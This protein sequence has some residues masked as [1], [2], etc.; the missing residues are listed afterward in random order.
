METIIPLNQDSLNSIFRTSIKYPETIAIRESSRI[1]FKESFNWGSRE[2]YARTLAAFAN[3]KGGYIIYGIVN[4]TLQLIG[5]KNDNFEKIDPGIISGYL[6]DAFSPEIKWHMLRYEFQD[7]YFGL[8]YVEESFD[9]PLIARKNIGNEIK[10]GEIYY[11]YR[12]RTEKIKYPELRKIIDNQQLKEREYWIKTF[13]KIAKVGVKN[14]GLF[15][16]KNGKVTGS[17]GSFIIDKSLFG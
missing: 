5:L 16:F 15:D 12:G 7:K 17:G 8:L 1:E 6:N 4:T 13:R 11:R 9:K 10:E 2:A 3:T 14:I